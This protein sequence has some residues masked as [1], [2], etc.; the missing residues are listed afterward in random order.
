MIDKKIIRRG[1]IHE[2]GNDF[3]FWQS[4]PFENRLAVLEEIRREYNS[5]KYGTEQRF[6]R[7]YRILKYQ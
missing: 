2:Q 1:K 4:Q 3:L 6:Q 5:W 7:V